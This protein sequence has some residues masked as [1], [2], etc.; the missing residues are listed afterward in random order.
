[1]TTIDATGGGAGL[2]EEAGDNDD[3]FEVQDM[4][5]QQPKSR[6]PQIGGGK[7]A[8]AKKIMDDQ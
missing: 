3:L 4:L 1:M 7:S 6:S 2:I 5:A 8:N